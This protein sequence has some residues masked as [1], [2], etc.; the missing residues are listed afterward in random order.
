[1]GIVDKYLKR[2]KENKKAK[3]DI[4]RFKN[5]NFLTKDYL[6]L[7]RKRFSKLVSTSCETPK[8]RKLYEA[9]KKIVYESFKGENKHKKFRLS[10]VEQL[11][12]EYDILFLYGKK[13]SGK[14]WQ[15]AQ[16]IKNLLEKFPDAQIAFIRNSLEEGKGFAEMM[17][18]SDNWVTYTDGT[19]VWKKSE[20]MKVG[21]FQ[22]HKIKPCG[23]FAYCTHGSKGMEKWQGGD[24]KNIRFW[25]WD[26][27]NSIEGGLTREVF[28][29]V[30]VFLSSMIRD[31]TNVKGL[32]TGNLLEKNNI[33]LHELGVNSA[34][35]LKIFEVH[36]DNNPKKPLLSRMLYLNTGDLFKGIEQQV[37]LPTQFLS[38]EE[39]ESLLSN[40]PG[41]T[42]TKAIY[43]E[44][45]LKNLAPV[46]SFV[47]RASEEETKMGITRAKDV[48]Y[49]F[50]VYRLPN[51]IR[52][53]L[54]I[55]LFKTTNIKPGFAQIYANDKCVINRYP[56]VIP[57]E[58]EED[59]GDSFIE[60]LA[61]YLLAGE[62]WFGW[63]QTQEVFEGV[64]PQLESKYMKEE[65]N[66]K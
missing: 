42:S 2:E 6:T 5:F 34:T 24:W 32:M 59:F 56:M 41:L 54:W 21:K 64:W 51:A 36:Q 13:D 39:L 58:E 19:Y 31:K 26:E 62:V 49:I 18:N 52:M 25:Y 40:R 63:N 66:E 65:T 38:D 16:Y 8:E 55:D 61:Q 23:I 10:H 43:E 46:F 15:A 3:T 9:Y 47:Y 27:C 48:D 57:I 50:Y 35:R 37:G 33:F 28:Q 45:D 11:G 53:I 60:P 17:N 4:K 1:M 22:K 44:G 29:R 30:V 12:I 20:Y 14:T 7:Q